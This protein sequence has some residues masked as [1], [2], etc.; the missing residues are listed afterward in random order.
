MFR[1]FDQLESTILV[2][3]QP[4]IRM[5]VDGI[6]SVWIFV[7]HISIKYIHWVMMVIAVETIQFGWSVVKMKLSQV[8]LLQRPQLQQPQLQQPQLHPNV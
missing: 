8:A 6:V 3:D 7:K 1:S 2:A 4:S 5:K